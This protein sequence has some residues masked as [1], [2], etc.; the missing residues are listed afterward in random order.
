M[1]KVMLCIFSLV[2][3]TACNTIGGFGKDVKGAGQ[4]VENAADRAK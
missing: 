1:I 2:V 4:A 3:L